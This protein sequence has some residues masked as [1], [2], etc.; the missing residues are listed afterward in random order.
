MNR[1]FSF[2]LS[3]F[4]LATLGLF[5]LGAPRAVA[6]EQQFEVQGTYTVTEQIGHNFFGRISGHATSGGH[7]DGTL[8]SQQRNE[9]LVGTLVLV[10]NGA[11]ITVE[12]DLE[13]ESNGGPFV[14]TYEIVDGATG[15]GEAFA[16][17]IGA[18]GSAAFGL[19]GTIER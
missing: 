4:S 3:V 19:S 11:S 6:K 1:F 5:A 17:P 14:G 15:S 18:D 12:F 16:E 10:F 2:R 8:E 7:F 13:R 9:R